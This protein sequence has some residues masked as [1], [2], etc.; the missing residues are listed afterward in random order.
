M[1]DGIP[2]I[3]YSWGLSL[4]SYRATVHTGSASKP[5]ISMD[6]HDLLLLREREVNKS[7][8]VGVLSSKSLVMESGIDLL[9][10]D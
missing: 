3:F 10:H 9:A 2:W 1:L 6:S 5:L 8:V 4:S 7:W